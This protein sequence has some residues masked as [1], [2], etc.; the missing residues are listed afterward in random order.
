MNLSF[1]TLL[2]QI[3]SISVTFNLLGGVKKNISE[4]DIFMLSFLSYLQVRAEGKWETR[5]LS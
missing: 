1:D 3:F 5:C 4:V 2:G